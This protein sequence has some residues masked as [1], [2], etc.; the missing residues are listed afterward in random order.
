VKL[1]LPE[2][3]DWLAIAA[4]AVA[5]HAT[6]LGGGFIWLDH[7]HLEEGLAIAPPDEWPSLFTRG[8]AGTGFY[9][10][11]MSLSL[12]LDRLVSDGPGF[13]RAVTLAWH[14]AASALVGVAGRT[15]GLSRRAA[16]VAGALFAVHPLTS[17]VAGAIAFRSEAMILAAL[18]VLVIAHRLERPVLAGLA[19]LAGG[20]TKETAWL[21][22]PLL[23][24]ALELE[25]RTRAKEH[26][27]RKHSRLLLAEALAFTAITAMRTAYAPAWRASFEGLPLGEA[28]GTRLAAFARSSA[29]LLA[30]V[31]R[32]ICDASPV[33]SLASLPALA[34]ALALGALAVFV[35]S[36]RGTAVL[37]A[38]SLLPALNLVPVMRFWSP[39]YLYVPLA[40]LAICVGRRLER[41]DKPG[42]LAAAALGM[43]FLATSLHD[44]YRYRTDVSLFTPEIERRDQ[45]L[46]AHFYLGDT[47]VEASDWDRAALHYQKASQP[48]PGFLA[49]VDR[50]A[51]LQNLGVMRLIQRRFAEARTAFGTALELTRDPL[52]KRKLTTNL[53]LAVLESGD[54]SEAARLL[55]AETARSDALQ[56]AL[57]TRTRA[58]HALGRDEEALEL[59]QRVWK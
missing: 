39:H 31:D 25:R 1:A 24:G 7:T 36:E 53:A 55:E 6:A 52:E 28:I 54:P 22:A 48:L 16:L 34:G 13:A 20:L 50:A 43:V 56:E 15:L 4:L 19:L 32:S 11:L 42:L 44:G 12:S 40:F 14:A 38:L 49:Y 45:C 59:F 41:L 26:P 51:A 21:L 17:L 3:V 47:A 27:G 37:F 2:R 35:R 18:L 58:L 10:P 29:A 30:P 8:F 33:S 23:I 46:E 57:H 5:A 9:R